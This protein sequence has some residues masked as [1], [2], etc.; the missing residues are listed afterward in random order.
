MTEAAGDGR[1]RVLEAARDQ[2]LMRQRK[3]TAASVA[4]RLREAGQIAHVQGHIVGNGRVAGTSPHGN[5]ND[6][7]VGVGVLVQIAADLVEAAGAMLSGTNHYAGAALLRQVVEVEYLT[8]AFANSKRD[9]ASWLNSTKD[10]RFKMFQPKDLRNASG[11]HFLSADYSHHCE[12]GGH[13]VPRAVPLLAKSDSSHSQLLLVDLLLHGWRTTDNVAAW[14]KAKGADELLIP[15]EAA[16]EDFAH[17]GRI[18][19]LYGWSVS[20]RPADDSGT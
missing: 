11:G 4:P 19:P 5:G 6:A 8:W 2:D 1:E 12:L 15:V 7:L 3:R 18:D 20:Q 10:D 9:A 16:R 13:P 17:W 14:A